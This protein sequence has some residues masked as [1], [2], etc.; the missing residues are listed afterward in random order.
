M[1]VFTTI[2]R[3]TIQ[4]SAGVVKLYI[5]SWADVSANVDTSTGLT[6]F[7]PDTSLGNVFSKWTL[8][9]ETCSYT[10]PGTGA[11]TTGTHFNAHT[12]NIIFPTLS[13]LKR[14]QIQILIGTEVVVVVV[15][16]N[17]QGICL[18]NDPDKGLTLNAND[19]MSGVAPGDAKGLS[20]SLVGNSRYLP[21][22]VDSSIVSALEES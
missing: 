12:M 3:D 11:M 17:G 9:P 16:A 22:L 19:M 6:T 8:R 20:V 2:P 4:N 5:A 14:N 21:S 13:A 10:A 18:G 15:D 1:G 7:T